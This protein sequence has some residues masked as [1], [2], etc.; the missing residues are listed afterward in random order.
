MNPLPSGWWTWMTSTS[1]TTS[2]SCR[3]CRT[4]C[5]RNRDVSMIDPSL[6]QYE[7]GRPIFPSLTFPSSQSNIYFFMFCLRVCVHTLIKYQSAVLHRERLRLR[8]SQRNFSCAERVWG[9]Q[10]QREDC[11]RRL[12]EPAAII[13]CPACGSWRLSTWWGGCVRVF[14]CA[15]LFI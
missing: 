11:A 4:S 13:L 7:R 6:S 3:L 12:I 8:S 15:G 10:A 9:Q 2:Q 1:A 14:V 5:F